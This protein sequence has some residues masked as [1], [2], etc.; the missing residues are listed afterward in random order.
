MLYLT[1]NLINTVHHPPILL[2]IL[3]AVLTVV[4]TVV[5]IVAQIA[6]LI[7]AQIAVPQVDKNVFKE[8]S[9]R[10]RKEIFIVIMVCWHIL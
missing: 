1:T 6:V 10:H 2:E 9:S 3:I 7:V 8:T 5:L 4:L